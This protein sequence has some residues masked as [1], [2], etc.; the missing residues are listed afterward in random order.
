MTKKLKKSS[1]TMDMLLLFEFRQQYWDLW[2]KFC[3]EKGYEENYID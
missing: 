1:V 2:K 3:N